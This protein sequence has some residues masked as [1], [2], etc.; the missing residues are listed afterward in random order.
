LE[1][2]PG[3]IY[4]LL[5]QNGVGKTTLLK[6]ICGL[7]PIKEGNCQVIGCNPF[8]RDPSLL[9]E[10][11]YVPEDFTPPEMVVKEYV[12]NRGKFYPRFDNTKFDTIL[13]EFG[14][15]G[16]KKI[17]KLSYGQQKKAII[18]FALSANVRILLLDEPSNGLDIPSKSQLRKIIASSANDHCCII[19]ST[20][21]VRDLENLL[22]PII[23]LDSNTILLNESITSISEKLIFKTKGNRDPEALLCDNAP[24]G[25]LCVTKNDT[26]EESAVNIEALFNAVVNKKEEIKNIF[27]S[28]KIDKDE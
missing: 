27:N 15:D 22:D 2:K 11:F 28:K 21:Q 7:L 19:I 10:I 3:N 17:S 4:G 20:H 6:I 16:N 1:L 26:G 25:Y 5:G 8:K 24:G 23:I 18:A 13:A 14:V 12:K 9:E